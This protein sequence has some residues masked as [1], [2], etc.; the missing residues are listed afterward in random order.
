MRVVLTGSESTGKTELAPLLAAHYGTV[1][2]R[3][4]AREYAEAR[5]GELDA[6]DV[7]PIARGQLRLQ[8]EA[9]GSGNAIVIHDTD[10]LSTIVYARH[11]YGR[12]PQWIV[13]ASAVR[14]PDLYLL[15]D[16]DLPWKADVARDALESREEIQHKFE[17]AVRESGVP[18]RLIRGGERRRFEA[19]VEAIEKFL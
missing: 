16:I 11:Y 17:I 13:D 3:E 19:A 18:W 9:A 8:D 12:C 2:S 15:M 7:E 5:G 6:S 1:W 14:I 4:Y 10:I